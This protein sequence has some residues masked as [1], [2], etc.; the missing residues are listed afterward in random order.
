MKLLG[1]KVFVYFFMKN[2]V[3]N[4]F[5]QVLYLKKYIRVYLI[6][7]QVYSK[8]IVLYMYLFFQVF[9]HLCYYRWLS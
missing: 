2:I 4:F 9:P 3:F 8:V 6:V 1:H 7:F 5:W